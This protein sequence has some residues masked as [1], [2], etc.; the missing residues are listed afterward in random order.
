M[1]HYV[2]G[3]LSVEEDSCPYSTQQ[4]GDSQEYRPCFLIPP[5]KV[6][7][8]LLRMTDRNT[9]ELAHWPDR[10]VFPV[11]R[12]ICDVERF[13]DKRTESMTRKGMWVCYT[14]GSDGGQ[15]KIINTVHENKILNRYY[16]PHHESL[17]KM[18]EDRMRVFGCCLIVDVHSF[19]PTA[20]PY[21]PNQKDN[22]P[23]ICIGTDNYHTPDYLKSFT[24]LFFSDQGY[25]TACD[26]PYSGAITPLGM[27]KREP[28]LAS[29]MIEMNRRLYMDTQT[30][31]KS[32][33][34]AALKKCMGAYLSAAEGRLRLHSEAADIKTDSLSLL[35]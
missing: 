5:D 35:R 14:H 12:L 4:P 21:E 26:D 11:S 18:A 19:S 13:R 33:G 34:Y 27:Y 9:D 16:D 6:E 3:A 17:A 15:I 22:R 7:M 8:E 31:V 1:R 20:L 29:I 32:A 24:Q 10:L 25:L 2:K 30:G 28:R 23:D